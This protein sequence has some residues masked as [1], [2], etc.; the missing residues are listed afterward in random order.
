[1]TDQGRGAR[2]RTPAA[3]VF[4]VIMPFHNEARTLRTALERLLA[5]DL[6]LELE[7]V[8]VDDGSYDSGY[9]T[10]EDLVDGEGVRLLRKE[11]GGKGSAVRAGFDHAR[12]DIAGVLDADLEYDPEDF[13]AL[14]AP[15]LSG[16]A[17]V[18]YGTRT[19]G[20]G[21]TFSPIYVLGNRVT[22]WFAGRLF[23]EKV[24]D[25]HTCLKVA[26]L[27]LWRSLGLTKNG[28][29][30]DP[31][32]TARFLKGGHHIAEVPGSYEARSRAEGK[33]LYWTDG[34]RTVAVLTKVRFERSEP[35]A[36]YSRPA[37]VHERTSSGTKPQPLGE[38]PPSR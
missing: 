21:R 24:S 15:I 23:G 5:V 11:R 34:L 27:E 35:G 4:S 38:M 2:K 12:G 13:R 8:L 30:L 32:A 25:I 16:E 3:R 7:V 19:L 9:L 17:E 33:K 22:S 37:W 36:V 1:M 26:P 20:G 10:I 29:D 14:L 6:P 18:A 28:F 31:E